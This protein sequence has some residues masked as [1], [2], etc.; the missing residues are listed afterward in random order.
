MSAVKATAEKKAAVRAC[1]IC[2]KEFTLEGTKDV[3]CICPEC[4]VRLKALLYAEK[5]ADYLGG[6]DIHHSL[7]YEQYVELIEMCRGNNRLLEYYLNKARND[8]NLTLEDYVALE[9]LSRS[10]PDENGM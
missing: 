9:N 1:V 5:P 2:G 8:K 10:T 6:E 4:A 7:A 3:R